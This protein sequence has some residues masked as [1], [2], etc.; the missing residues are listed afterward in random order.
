MTIQ[1][2]F[3]YLPEDIF[4]PNFDNIQTYQELSKDNLD[5]T[6][7]NEIGYYKE[8]NENYHILSNDRVDNMVYIVDQPEIYAIS[9]THYHRRG[10]MYAVKIYK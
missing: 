9:I 6:G 5:I 4:K 3:S 7:D 10:Q 8:I 2:A 1:E